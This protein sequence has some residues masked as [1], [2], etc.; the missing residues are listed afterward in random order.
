MR[1]LTAML[2]L[3][4]TLLGT[5]AVAASL[6]AQDKGSSGSMMGRGMMGDGD[7]GMMG[8]MS[9]MVD[10]CNGMMS[11]NRPNDQWR[12]NAPAEPDQR[13]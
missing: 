2:L 10:R 9:Q 4:S 12:K 8:M 6:D 11:N 3:G 1:K 13:G 7:G 5:A